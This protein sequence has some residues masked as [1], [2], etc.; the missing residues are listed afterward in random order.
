[1]PLEQL[2]R[3]QQQYGALNGASRSSHHTRSTSAAGSVRASRSQES[4]A[5]GGDRHRGST[6][7]ARIHTSPR[8][9]VSLQTTSTAPRPSS[10][11]HHVTGIATS[12]SSSVESF[13][14]YHI[15]SHS[16]AGTFSCFASSS[17]PLSSFSYVRTTSSRPPRV[18]QTL[19]GH[20]SNNLAWTFLSAGGLGEPFTPF[21]SFRPPT[22]PSPFLWQTPSYNADAEER[23]AARERRR[24]EQAEFERRE[25]LRLRREQELHWEREQQDRTRQERELRAAQAAWSQYEARWQAMQDG[26]HAPPGTLLTFRDIPWPVVGS[27]REGPHCLTESRL[28]AFLQAQS[29]DPKVLKQRAKEMLLRYHPDRFEGRWMQLVRQEDVLLVKDGV[30]R[31]TRFLNGFMQE[32]LYYV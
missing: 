8:V 23:E 9:Q 4:N 25:E 1:M 10:E 29:N 24:E 22:P 6:P 32:L 3:E 18:S 7:I 27:M 26:T 2:Q 15:T 14:S 12:V 20:P 30:E 28:R 5:S 11:W 19:F 31:V 13:A 17:T 21:S 16:A